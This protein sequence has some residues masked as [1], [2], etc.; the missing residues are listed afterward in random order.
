MNNARRW[1]CEQDARLIEAYDTGLDLGLIALELERSHG[2]IKSRLAKHHFHI[3]HIKQCGGAAN[4]GDVA[5]LMWIRNWLVNVH[6]ENPD[7]DYMRRLDRIIEVFGL[8]VQ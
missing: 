3:E 8:G 7:A 5:H 4:E 6:S 2:A 1:T